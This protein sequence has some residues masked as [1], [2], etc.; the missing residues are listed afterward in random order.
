MWYDC[1]EAPQGHDHW[2]LRLLAI[3]VVELWLLIIS[4]ADHFSQGLVA[5]LDALAFLVR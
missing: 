4:G 1:S 2:T 5:G 3:R